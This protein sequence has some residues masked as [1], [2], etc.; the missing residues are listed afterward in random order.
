LS[1]L[2]DPPFAVIERV[3]EETQLDEAPAG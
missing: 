3:A 1:V 2:A